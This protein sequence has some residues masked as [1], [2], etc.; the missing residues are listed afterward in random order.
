MNITVIINNFLE[1]IIIANTAQNATFAPNLLVRKFSVY[2]QFP[3]IFG[4]IDRKSAETVRL[5]KISS[6][7]T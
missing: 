3:Q 6:S 7:G 4:R 2:G 1:I 5:L